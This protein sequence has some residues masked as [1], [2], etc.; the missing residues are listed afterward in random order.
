[1]KKI[2]FAWNSKITLPIAKLGMVSSSVVSNYL[3]LS[4]DIPVDI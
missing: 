3:N 2:I 1:M 4:V